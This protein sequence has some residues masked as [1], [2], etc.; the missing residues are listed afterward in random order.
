MRFADVPLDLLDEL[1]VGVG[2]DDLAALAVDHLAHLVLL[3]T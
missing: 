1:V 2:A 3:S